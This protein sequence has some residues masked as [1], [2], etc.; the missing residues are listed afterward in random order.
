MSMV[1]NCCLT[2]FIDFF[3]HVVIFIYPAGFPV[4]EMHFHKFFTKNLQKLFLKW[5]TPWEYMKL[6]TRSKK[7]KN[8][9]LGEIWSP[10]DLLFLEWSYCS[11]PEL[12]SAQP[13]II[14]LVCQGSVLKDTYLFS[15]EMG[16]KFA[17]GHFIRTALYCGWTPFAR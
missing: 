6:T 1:D 7:S 9:L 15:L 14:I 3:D 4:L 12:G 2:E 8:L 13:H 5:E 10:S 16:T 11:C 17:F